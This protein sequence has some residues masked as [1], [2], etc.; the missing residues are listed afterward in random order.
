MRRIACFFSALSLMLLS[1]AA[2]CQSASQLLSEARAAE[3]AGKEDVAFLLYK[4][5]VRL[6]PES[7]CAEEAQFAVG[8]YHY[9]AR[10]FF[11]ASRIF[12]DF[13]QKYPGSRFSD[14]AREYLERIQSGSLKD[15][16]NRLFE[17]GKLQAASVLYQEYLEADPSDAE[18]K[19]RLEQIRNIQQEVHFGFEQ[20]SRERKK[21]QQE[22]DI[23]AR[24]VAE[25][26]RQRKD[27]QAREKQAQEL[28]QA[29]VQKYEK[30]LA[31][32]GT[33]MDALRSR[34][35]SLEAQVKGWRHRTVMVEALRLSRP[36]AAGYR[37]VPEGKKLP[38]VEFEGSRPDPFPQ[39]GETQIT[40]VAKE[41]FPAVAITDEKLDTKNS[42][43]HVEAVVSVDLASPWPEEA[44]MKFRVDF[45]PKQGQPSPDP[46]FLVRYFEASDM[47][48]MDETT[49]SYRKRV[50]FTVQEKRVER[51][52]VSAFL[53]K[54]K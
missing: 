44:K 43:R 34:V 22:K 40:D 32:V 49:G 47:D 2:F 15:R 25:L 12:G 24:Q 48:D 20:V 42:L 9:D 10:N 1:A 54:T 17:E 21:L 36:L 29:T 52:E 11:D 23:L 3:S 27:V 35:T 33:Q 6:Y 50:P 19:A 8:K 4:R 53:V 38:R 26:D 51:Y 30:R 39:E 13:L 5:L 46:R 14:R 16:A 41:G 31:D 28:N 45:I 7:G 18:V 37:P